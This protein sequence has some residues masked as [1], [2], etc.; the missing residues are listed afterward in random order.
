MRW[1]GLLFALGFF[2]SQQVVFHIWR[3]EGMPD[4]DV[5]SLTVYMVVATIIGARLGHVL[6][7]DLAK[8]AKDPLGV[9][10]IWEGGLA[11]HG[12]AIGILLAIWMYTNR[13]LI[14]SVIPFK[15]KSIKRK[16]EG[17]SFLWVLDRL[18][19][20]VALTGALIRTGNFIN[21]EIIG[22]PTDGKWGVVFAWPLENR[23][24][25]RGED[26]IEDITV[27]QSDRTD[28]IEEG[29][30]PL[31][32]DITF[33]RQR[34]K[35][36]Q[37]AEQWLIAGRPVKAMLTNT[38]DTYLLEHIAEPDSLPL[39]YS[40]RTEGRNII[41]SVETT[42]IARQPSQLYEAFSTLLLG[43][44]LFMIWRKRKSKLPEGLLLGSFMVV[45][46][47]LRFVYE[48]TKENQVAFEDDYSYNMGQLLSIPMVIIGFL[49]LIRANRQMKKKQQE[50]NA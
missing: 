3:K 32:A 29:Y 25:E 1:Y 6:F 47:A 20:V 48:F 13:P 2:L 31:R 4:K 15:L 8:Y 34:I 11:S 27:V 5:E 18:V 33:K 19:I 43:I 22:K 39:Q 16:R 7:Y 45:L 10:R 35:T 14:F 24:Q 42:G 21:S 36:E 38:L 37:E 23:L 46:F 44:L 41:A 40:I 49:I 30:V 28:N 12:A 9:F 26:L 17:Q 50:P